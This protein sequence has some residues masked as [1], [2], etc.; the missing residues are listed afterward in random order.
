MSFITLSGTGSV[1]F[2]SKT[3][4]FYFRWGPCLTAEVTG[5]SPCRVSYQ[6]CQTT[7]A[8]ITGETTLLSVCF[9]LYLIWP[10]IC[11]CLTDVWITD[12]F[13]FN[14]IFTV[15]KFMHISLEL[16]SLVYKLLQIMANSRHWHPILIQKLHVLSTDEYLFDGCYYSI[17]IFGNVYCYFQLW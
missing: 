8:P 4:P 9:L 10:T 15:T 6:I 11:N 3:K 7:L 17:F 12:I 14:K 5:P 13:C 1:S 2:L 16:Y